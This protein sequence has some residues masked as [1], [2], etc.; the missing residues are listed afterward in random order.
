MLQ[1][2][3]SWLQTFPKW[4]GQL[5]LDYAD[6][7]PGSAGLYPRGIRELSRQEDVLGNRKLRLRCV[8]LLRR[9]ALCAEENARWLLELQ[10]WVA[11]QDSLGLT[12]K[13]GDEPKTERLRAYEGRLDRQNQ[14]GSSLY[15]VQLSAEYTKI[16][17]GES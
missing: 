17:R 1:T 6:A 13:F 9:S 4:E 12:P 7:V 16:F 3:E 14:D 5:Q 2:M 11:D 15:T 8:F 10:T